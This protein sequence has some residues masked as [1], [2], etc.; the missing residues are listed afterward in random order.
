MVT[1]QELIELL[2][3]IEDKTIPVVVGEL[4]DLVRNHEDDTWDTTYDYTPLEI[5]HIQE[6]YYYMDQYGWIRDGRASTFPNSKMLVIYT[7]I[8]SQ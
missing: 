5:S 6:M 8:F 1:V 3:M 2:E 7:G 4:L